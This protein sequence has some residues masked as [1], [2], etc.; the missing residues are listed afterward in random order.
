LELLDRHPVAGTVRRPPRPATRAELLAAHTAVHVARVEALS[1]QS[2]SLDPDTHLSPRSVDAAYLAAG[3]SVVAVE[4][5]LAGRA[6]NA[7][8]LVRPPGHHAEP[9]RAM[10]FCLFNNAA[11]AAQAALTHGARRVLVLDWDVHH[12]NGTQACFEARR[13]VLYQSLHQFPFYPGTGAV[14]EIGTGEGEGFTV[15]CPLP[16]GQGDGDYAVAF[17]ELLLP[18]AEAFAPD[19]VLVSAGFDPHEDDPLGGMQLTERGFK[20]MATAARRL[21]ESCCRGKLVLLLEGGY[22]LSG[23]ARS[24]H[25]CVE[26]LQGANEELPQGG[27]RRA[28]EAV[29]EAKRQ[30]RPFWPTLPG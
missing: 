27:G 30:L 28:L 1:G 22:S 20:A 10:G 18:I 4:E 29:T 15:N 26:S 9:E 23:L 7:F 21:A 3:A 2:A 14:Q 16:G 8:A 6:A 5:V 11:V 12:G 25:A 13:D 19:L 24:V 17:H